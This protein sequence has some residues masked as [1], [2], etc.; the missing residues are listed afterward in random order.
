MIH[1]K[2]KFQPSNVTNGLV[3][4]LSYNANTQRYNAVKV[5]GY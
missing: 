1:T 3:Y 2:L 5:A 4:F